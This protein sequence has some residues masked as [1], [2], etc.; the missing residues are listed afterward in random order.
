M[1][2]A[3]G[4]SPREGF[5][6]ESASGCSTSAACC[7][8]LQISFPAHRQENRPSSES[9]PAL[10][11]ASALVL[12]WGSSCGC[13]ARRG[14]VPAVLLPRGLRAGWS[15]ERRP[16]SCSHHRGG[17]ADDSRTFHC[18]SCAPISVSCGSEGLNRAWGIEGVW[19]GLTCRR[20]HLA[21]IYSELNELAI[22]IC[23][24]LCKGWLQKYL[25]GFSLLLHFCD[26]KMEVV[27]VR[28]IS[29]APSEHFLAV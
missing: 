20:I 25:C 6:A 3:L 4:L 13:T 8:P 2:A 21:V 15:T 18:P 9:S 26:C 24:F 27:T 5:G 1:G 23:L 19:F 7:M 28:F 11:G 10:S 29:C 17:A 22:F 14:S 16:C 12:L